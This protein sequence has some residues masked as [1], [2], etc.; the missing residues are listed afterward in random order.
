MKL[1]FQ[2]AAC[3]MLSA[4]MLCL[5]AQLSAGADGTRQVLVT[6]TEE[7]L[8]A[9]A[10]AQAGDEII[11][12]EG[13]Y[14]NDK[15][16][17]IWAAFYSE[18]E[19]TAQ[20]PIV[21]RSEDAAHP[22]TIRGVSQDSKV[23]LYIAGSHWQIR[24]LK[25]C[26][27]S[28]GI[29]LRHSDYSVISGCEVYNTGDEGI[30]II[31]NSSYCLVENT[32]VHDNGTVRPGYGE[33]I[34]IGSA[35]GNTDYGFD[36]H[37]NT[38]R[39][40]RLGPN[41]AAE[42]VDIKEY[43]V[44]NVVEDCIFDGT[45]ISGEN[46]A[47]SFVANKGNNG[48]VRRNI[49]YRS[50]NEQ[51]L[52]GFSLSVQ[53]DGWG[54]NNQFY[55]NTLYLDT[56]DCYVAK[57]WDCAAQVFRNVTEPEG[58]SCYGNK[59]QELT[60]FLMSC[61]VTDDGVVDADDAA[62]LQAYLCT[63]DA[64]YL[65]AVNADA[66][67]DGC[68]TAADLSL[69]KRALLADSAAEAVGLL[70]VFR[71]EDSGKWRMTNGLGGMTL[72]FVAAADAGYRANMGYGYWDAAEINPNTG[73]SGLWIQKSLGSGTFDDSGVLSV[74]VTVPEGVSNIAFEIY[75]YLAPNN[76]TKLDKNAVTLTRVVAE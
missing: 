29:F 5:S 22:A 61:D 49:G 8:A 56:E 62:R 63:D 20:Q 10:D 27:A 67:A 44:G 37:Y 23:A 51:I 60:G 33:A 21:L 66:D 59:I 16:V 1:H 46:Y 43:T 2:K 48:I 17:G 25:I 75:D 40:C 13:I 31:D 6:D 58:L 4:V 12:R 69:V 73:A 9:L 71:Q 36:C 34:Y 42:H 39:G 54:Q 30:H 50:G 32:Y 57:G 26:E 18:G 64:P 76:Q 55:E 14:E 74:T 65:S 38:V 15:W 41:T 35:K 72:T 24:D 19:G 68:L 47:N 45:G 7:L 11:L 3:C 53:L 28:K 70:P 52:Y